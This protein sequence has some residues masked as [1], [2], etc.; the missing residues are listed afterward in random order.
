MRLLYLILGLTLFLTSNLYGQQINSVQTFDDLKQLRLKVIKDSV[1]GKKFYFDFTKV[2]GCNKTFISYLG[3][4]KTNK[5]KN[6]KILICF[7]VHGQSCR[8]TSRIVIY[9]LDNKYIGNYCVTMSDLP[10]TIINNNL[11]YLKPDSDCNFRKGT[12]ISFDNGLPQNLFIPCD[13]ANSGEFYSFSN[14]E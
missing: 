1:I 3:Q 6:Y 13:K 4:I 5:N 14:D 8:G 12:K 10:D 9:D 7:Y 2:D 11:V